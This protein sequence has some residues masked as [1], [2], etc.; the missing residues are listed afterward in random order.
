MAA[1]Y[2]GG[3]GPSG[4]PIV[5]AVATVRLESL[6][7]VFDG[8]TA[9]DDVTLDIADREFMVLL[10]PSGC[11][12]STLLRMIAGLESPTNGDVLI[13][14]VRVNDAEPKERDVAM[15][16]QSYALYPHKTV[17]ANI[18]F[19][20]K[21]RKVDKVERTRAAEQAAAA[22]GLTEY[23][24]RKP[25]QL[26]GGQRQR[27]ALARAIVR[28]PAVFCM[29]EP[30]SNLDAKLR[31]ETRAELV[32]MHQR[33]S[34]T[35]VYVTHDQVEA[36]TMGTRVAV[37]NR[38][39]IEQVGTPAEVYARP[40]SVFVAE[41]IGTP[42][43]NVLPAGLADGP[44]AGGTQRVG[45]RPEHVVVDPAG[46]VRATVTL[47]EQLGH[48]VLVYCQVGD[49]RIVVRSSADQVHA[50]LGDE[51]GLRLPVEHRHHFDPTTGLAVD[52]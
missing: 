49:T 3:G 15:V 17:R 34:S 38:G 29:D 36:M 9:V 12:K 13:G 39:R 50:R 41:F 7:K 31:S 21:V 52:G 51:V 42:P 37:M 30:L 45:I 32:A 48:E 4:S 33:L 46:P 11:G 18:E 10:G 8:V 20:L 14:G 5:V 22:L 28:Q 23:L 26:S 27:V 2:L 6:T 16:F 35:F 44:G 43:M 25:G 47:V 19:P 40:A 24:E 1:G